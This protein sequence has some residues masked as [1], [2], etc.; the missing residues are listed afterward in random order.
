MDERPTV[1]LPPRRRGLLL[2]I[3][4][5]LVL[6]AVS[7]AAVFLAMRTAVG[8]YFVLLM[9]LALLLMG[10]LALVIYRGYALTQAAYTLERDGLRLRW[11]LR[12]EDIPLNAV[13]WVRPVTELGTALP[14]PPL[15]MPG[16]ILGTRRVEGLGPVEFMASEPDDLILL[17]VPARIFAISPA[18][19][20][21]FS[22]S[23]QR[24]IELGS[25][26]PLAARSARPAAYLQSTWDYR[27]VRILILTGA[28][29]SLALFVVTS[30]I[31]PTRAAIPLGFNA[32]GQPLEP[33]PSARLLLLPILG[34]LVY[35]TDLVGGLYFFRKLPARPVAYLLWASGAVTVL[36]LLVSLI[37]VM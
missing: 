5:G 10:P 16:A 30:L 18:D 3:G 15:S 36:L 29:L 13:E 7:A 23:F 37:F 11:G 1:F 22:R 26:S 28:A 21:A 31:I 32:A 14:T 35:L 19:P 20:R 6:A 12:S 9:L 33:G 8:A 27:A 34:A 2:H 24:A 25:L 17:A 4:L